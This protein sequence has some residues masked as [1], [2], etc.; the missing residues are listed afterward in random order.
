MSYS[1][2][3]HVV[4]LLS[5]DVGVARVPGVL[6]DDVHVDEAQRHLAQ[7]FVRHR[8]IQ[9]E[10]GR[11]LPGYRAGAFEF[12]DDGVDGLVGAYVPARVVPA[13]VSGDLLAWLAA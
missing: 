6:R 11:D 2:A 1:V 3:G 7:L 13:R 8:V 10:A 12:G 5:D 4:D 9:G